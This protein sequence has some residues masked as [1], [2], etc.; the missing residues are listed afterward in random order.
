MGNDR[1][2]PIADTTRCNDCGATWTDTEWR[3]AT[4]GF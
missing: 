4:L 3:Q 2:N 1:W